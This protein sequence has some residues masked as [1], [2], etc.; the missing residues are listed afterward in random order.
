MKPY[1]EKHLTIN[2]QQ[3]TIYFAVNEYESSYSMI[4][5]NDVARK[6]AEYKFTRETAL[7]FNQATGEDLEVMILDVIKADIQNGII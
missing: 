3:Y 2:H 1:R 6:K 4:V 7:D 5:S